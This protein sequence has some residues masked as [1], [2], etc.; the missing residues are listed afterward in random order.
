MNDH[1][2][3]ASGGFEFDSGVNTQTGSPRKWD[4]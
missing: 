4:Y 2:F 1:H 3:E